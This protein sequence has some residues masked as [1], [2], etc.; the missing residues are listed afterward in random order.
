MVDRRECSKAPG[1]GL[2]RRV[3]VVEIIPRTGS[4]EELHGTTGAEVKGNSEFDNDAE[5]AKSIAECDRVGPT[6]LDPRTSDVAR[7]V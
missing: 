2:C 4:I 5:W 3:D 7:L 6:C 1:I